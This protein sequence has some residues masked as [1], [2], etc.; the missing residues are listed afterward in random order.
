MKT[1]TRLPTR[2]MQL[3]LSAALAAPL[4]ALAA[5][6]PDAANAKSYAIRIPVTAAP[7]A[8]L[9]RLLLPAEALVRL[10]SAGYSDLRLFNAAGQPV[11]MALAQVPTTHSTE[12]Q[13]VK[14]SAYPILGSAT[15]TAAGLEGL[16]LRIEERQGRRV[17]QLNTTGST[18]AGPASQQKVLGALLDAR[19]VNLP[20]V[21]L[22]L[23]A[24]L[25]VGQPVTFNVQASKDLK[26]WRPL[27]DTVLYRADASAPA[28][29]LG[30]SSLALSMAELKDHYLRITWGDAAVTLRGATLL[31]SRST[32]TRERV[33]A[34]MAAPAMAG[35]RELSFA[36]PFATPVAAL[37]ITPKDSNVLVP[38]RVLGRNDRNQ[39][40]AL[41]ATAVVYRLT[42]A[43]KEQNSGPVELQGASVREVK[44]EADA[45][46]PGFASAP[47]IV[48]QFEPAQL[49]FLASGQ[50]PFT[51]AAGLAGPTGAAGAFLPMA[52]L[53]PG[54]KA[55]Q[56]NALPVAKADVSK[57]D[58][59]GGSAG[60]AGPLVAAQAPGD[61]IPTRSLVLWGILLLGALALGAMAWVLMK[62][63]RQP[64]VQGQ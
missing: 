25:P 62:Q 18:T 36:L 59:T 12:E 57:A 19:A 21:R 7:D 10:Q 13:Q 2:W 48:L 54:Y 1:H 15:A 50:G 53:I 35:P 63:T 49:V 33:S 27:A 45:K 31:T 4:L 43:G 56:E 24:D 20:A 30:E 9:Q 16:S 47:D 42:T 14:L 28:A 22:T 29:S 38:I 23:D 39:P 17:V 41:L 6:A 11:P 64:P 55:S 8:P 5:D 58:A 32:A 52:S 46:T 40:W 44:I 61:G 37:K 3:A 60:L 51:L 26:S 34:T